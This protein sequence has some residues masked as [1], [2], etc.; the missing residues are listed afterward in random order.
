MQSYKWLPHPFLPCWMAGFVSFPQGVERST[1]KWPGLTETLRQKLVRRSST[2]TE[3]KMKSILKCSFKTATL[4]T[5][6]LFSQGEIG[7]KDTQK[8]KEGRMI[9][10]KKR[11]ISAELSDC[12]VPL[13][14]CVAIKSVGRDGSWKWTQHS[15]VHDLG[16]TWQNRS[17]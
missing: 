17:P 12:A 9:K 11:H 1:R 7:Y 5:D 16:L 15:C 14:G 10:S 4:W 2:K 6:V 8:G 13:G 3:V